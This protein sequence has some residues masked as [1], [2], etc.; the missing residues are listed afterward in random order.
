[1]DLG[2]LRQTWASHR[3]STSTTVDLVVIHTNEGRE[4]PVSAENLA[5]YLAQPHVVPGYHF[6]V[7]ENSIVQGCPLSERTNGAGGVNSRAIHVCI[8]GYAAQ[9]EQEWTDASSTAAIELAADL[10]AELCRRFNVPNRRI[11]DP[12][13]GNRGVCGHVDVSRY[14]TA[15]AGHYDPGPHFPWGWLFTPIMD[16]MAAEDVNQIKASIMLAVADLGGRIDAV[17]A[18]VDTVAKDTK[19][20]RTGLFDSAGKSIPAKIWRRL[21]GNTSET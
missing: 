5:A 8:T 14:Y 12:R 17:D 2:N 1:M 15:S 19:K 3:F 4:G 11:T 20:V 7:D 9:S 10:V 16:D 18:K 13:P 6:I 21:L